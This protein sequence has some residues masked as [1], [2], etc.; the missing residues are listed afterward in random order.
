MLLFFAFFAGVLSVLAP[1]VLPVL[2]V[3]L[4]A[5]LSKKN[6]TSPYVILWSALFFIFVFTFLLKVSTLFLN[7]DARVWNLISAIIIILYGLILLFPNIWD[8]IKSSFSSQPTTMKKEEKSWFWAEVLLGASL[9]PIFASCSPTYALI[10]STIL[11]QNLFMG[12]LSILAYILGFGAVLLI[13]IYFGQEAI[14]KLRRYANPNGI[15]KKVIAILLILTGVLIISW[16]FKWIETQLV[17]SGF[18]ATLTRIEQNALKNN[19]NDLP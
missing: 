18:G 14:K 8:Q 13:V 19:L 5:G 10:I 17:N 6:Q 11:P 3:I 1:C 15:F 4:W 12:T 16:G 2:P 9:G 7:I